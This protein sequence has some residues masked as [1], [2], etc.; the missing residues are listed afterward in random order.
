MQVYHSYNSGYSR[1][2]YFRDD[3]T[4]FLHSNLNLN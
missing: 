2:S 4:W 1:E 3:G